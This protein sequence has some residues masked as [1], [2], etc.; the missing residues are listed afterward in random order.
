MADDYGDLVELGFEGFDRVTDKYHDTVHDYAKA[1]KPKLSPFGKHGQKS[2]PHQDHS[3]Q[4]RS[5]QDRANHDRAHD[6]ANPDLPPHPEGPGQQRSHRRPP[7]SRYGESDSEPERE[8]PRRRNMSDAYGSDRRDDWRDDRYGDDRSYGE[9]D[10]NEGGYR[11]DGREKR[12]AG[13][14]RDVPGRGRDGDWRDDGVS[15]KTYAPAYGASSDR[16]YKVGVGQQLAVTNGTQPP[17]APPAQYGG[18]MAARGRP[19][20]SRRGSSW[21]PPRR[22]GGDGRRN[23]SHSRRERSKSANGKKRAAAVILGALAGGLAG[24]RVKKD[25]PVANSVSTVLGAVVG[26]LGAREAEQLWDKRQGGRRTEEGGE[27]DSRGERDGRRERRKERERDRG[28]D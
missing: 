3:N 15:D 16:G 23:K 1:H 22:S 11:G 9:Q 4:D 26:G 21:S 5:H 6:R 7:R 8:D 17:G 18:A 10:Q 12:S 24:S 25:Q 2:H 27:R 19:E 13:R 14:D 20:P 28:Y